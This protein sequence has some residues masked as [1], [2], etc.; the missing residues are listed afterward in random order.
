MTY[1]VLMGMLNPTHSLTRLSR[2]H[3]PSETYICCGWS[4][5]MSKFQSLHASETT[6]IWHSVTVADCTATNKQ[7]KT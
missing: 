5:P 2:R 3:F 1:D 6:H 7:Q 4:S